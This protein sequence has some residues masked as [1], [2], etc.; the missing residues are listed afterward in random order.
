MRPT[1]HFVTPS[2]IFW[3]LELTAPRVHQALAYANRYYEL[4]RTTRI[5]ATAAFERALTGR[6]YLTRAELGVRLA[7]AGI[8]VKGVRLALLTCTRSSRGSCAVALDAE[9]RGR[10]RCL[11]NASP[12]RGVCRVTSRSPSSP[13]VFQKS[14]PGDDERFHLVLRAHDG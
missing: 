8:A 5:R 13:T 11:R 9:S 3:M 14:W 4:D 10:M 6:Q 2:D 12:R 7:R 1:W